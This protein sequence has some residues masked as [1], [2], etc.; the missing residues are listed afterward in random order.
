MINIPSLA[1]DV[2]EIIFLEP[3]KVSLRGAL[4]IQDRVLLLVEDV[5]L[6]GNR[7]PLLVHEELVAGER[8]MIAT[9]DGRG[10]ARRLIQSRS[11]KNVA[12]LLAAQ[13]LAGMLILEIIV[14]L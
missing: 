8:R 11:R 7:D 13:L 3:P 9:I 10:V 2:I 1:E 5:I 6:L 14:G 12:A 4:D